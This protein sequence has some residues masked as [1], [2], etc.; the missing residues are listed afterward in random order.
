LVQQL[1]ERG[2]SRRDSVRVLNFIFEQVKQALA[3]DEEVEFAGGKLTRVKKLSRH[4][5]LI[6]DEPMKPWTVDWEL[7][8]EG[9]EELLGPLKDEERAYLEAVWKAPAPEKVERRGRKRVSARSQR[10]IASRPPQ[11]NAWPCAW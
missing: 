7:S 4:W 10:A 1:G 2:T 9:Q 5:E 8:P 3:R 11:C 6:G